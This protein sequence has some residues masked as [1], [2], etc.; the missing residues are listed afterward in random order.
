MQLVSEEMKRA[1]QTDIKTMIKE[2]AESI[3]GRGVYGESEPEIESIWS[4]DLESLLL[5]L[6]L[7]LLKSLIKDNYR[8]A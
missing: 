8:L 3:W 2:A 4:R 1:N 7:K 5:P 6:H